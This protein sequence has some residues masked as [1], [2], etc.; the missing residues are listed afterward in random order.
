MTELRHRDE[1]QLV[2]HPASAERQQQFDQAVTEVMQSFCERSEQETGIRHY[3]ILLPEGPKL[4][5]R[6]VPS[7]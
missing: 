6:V 5:Q 4:Y 7:A 1:L 2:G 3:I